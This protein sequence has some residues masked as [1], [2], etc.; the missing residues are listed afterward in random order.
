MWC[1]IPAAGKGSRISAASRGRPKA[2]VDVG[3]ESLL[4][5]LLV[6]VQQAVSGV[7]VVVPPPDEGGRLLEAAVKAARLSVP[8]LTVVQHRRSGVADAVLRCEGMVEGPFVVIM[9]DVYYESRVA[10]YVEALDAAPPPAVL[11]EPVADASEH[12]AGVVT[13]ENGLLTS[14]DKR[15]LEGTEQFRIA[16]AFAFPG[17]A[18]SAFHEARPSTGEFELEAVMRSLMESNPVRTI[19]YEGWRR[20]VN[21]PE[22]LRAV[23]ERAR[24]NAE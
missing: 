8:A 19:V 16:G 11:V 17:G 2:L 22:D 18:F 10:P 20:N 21:T 4:H 14:V 23:R 6:D 13:V 1:I 12:P 9:G 15:V 7:C 24:R 5:R 3:G